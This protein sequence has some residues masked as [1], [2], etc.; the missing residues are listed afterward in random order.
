[1]KFVTSLPRVAQWERERRLWPVIATATRGIRLQSAADTGQAF[2]RPIRPGRQAADRSIWRPVRCVLAPSSRRS[3]ISAG[4]AL[5]DRCF[6][7]CQLVAQSLALLFAERGTSE[8]HAII[9][10]DDRW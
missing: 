8:A 3:S 7:L 9:R 6:E 10:L 1:M 5:E 2:L 4:S